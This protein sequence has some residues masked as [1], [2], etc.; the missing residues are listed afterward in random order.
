MELEKETIERIRSG[1]NEA[2]RDLYSKS[3]NTTISYLKR[4]GASQIEAEDIFQEAIITVYEN[5]ILGRFELTS[6]LQTYIVVVARNRLYRHLRS[7]KVKTQELIADSEELNQ[8]NFEKEQE[9]ISKEDKQNH[10]MKLVQ[11]ALNQLGEPCRSILNLYY[12]KGLTT[13]EIAEEFGYTHASLKV[14]RFRCMQK[15]RELIKNFEDIEDLK[16]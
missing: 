16:F 4:S 7:K 9:R 13:K 2:L 3:R 15:L 6:S 1:D 12:M 11:N 14:K 5:I 8:V 10:Q